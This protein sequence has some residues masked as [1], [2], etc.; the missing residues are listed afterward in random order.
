MIDLVVA[1]VEKLTR[2]E[3]YN[4]Q[5]ITETAFGRPS[6]VRQTSRCSRRPGCMHF[7]KGFSWIVPYLAVK[8]NA[9]PKVLKSI[10]TLASETCQILLPR[11]AR[12]FLR[13]SRH[14]HA[15]RGQ[16]LLYNFDNIPC[17]SNV[18]SYT[19]GIGITGNDFPHT[20]NNAEV[21]RSALKEVSGI[22]ILCHG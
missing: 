5:S 13:G 1:F 22:R 20:F 4:P 17:W 15:S 8:L 21:T 6:G 18:H 14:F 19:N 10:V 3:R 2:E 16:C 7:L 11:T 9:A 12:P